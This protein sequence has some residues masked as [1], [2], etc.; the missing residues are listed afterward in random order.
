MSRPT[1]GLTRRCQELKNSRCRRSSSTSVDGSTTHEAARRPCTSSPDD[2]RHRRWQKAHPAVDEG[3]VLVG[4]GV[5]H[6][7]LDH[8]IGEPACLEAVLQLP[9]SFVVHGNGV[10]ADLRD[11]RVRRQCS[12]RVRRCQCATTKLPIDVVYNRR[13]C[14]GMVD[15]TGRTGIGFGAAAALGGRRRASC[16]AALRARAMLLAA[17][18]TA[19]AQRRTIGSRAQVCWRFC[20]R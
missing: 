17:C 2:H 8:A 6:D 11:G 18:A 14:M 9:R 10:H 13:A 4:E 20:R 5:V 12:R 16:C 1:C 3:A 15:M 7:A 19:P